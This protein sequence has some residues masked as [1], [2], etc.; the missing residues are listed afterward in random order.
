MLQLNNQD[1]QMM[2]FNLLPH[3]ESYN[4]KAGGEG[5]AYFVGDQFVVKKFE[6][7]NG[8]CSQAAFS[9]YAEEVQKFGKMGYHVPQIYA[10]LTIP[11]GRDSFDFYILEEQLKGREI[12][13][14]FL[15]GSYHLFE[16]MC[17]KMQF[18]ALMIDPKLNMTMFEE[19]FKRFIGDYVM[20]NE[21]LLD[22]NENELEK[23]FLDVNGMFKNGKRSTPDVYHGNVF[24]T[25][26]GL[27]LID[28]RILPDTPENLYGDLSSEDFTISRSLQLLDI[29]EVAWKDYLNY[30]IQDFSSNAKVDTINLA[31]K[32]EMYTKCLIE[33]FIKVLNRA[34]S[35]PTFSSKDEYVDVY[36]MMFRIFGSD[37]DAEKTL[38]PINKGFE[39]E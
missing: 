29:N 23:F 24:L 35:N 2:L 14:G 39:W 15:G 4:Q 26:S 13:S 10:W 27:A 36:D 21:M 11:K 32:H 25:D 17:S 8:F 37:E 38:K 3:L 7:N 31:S 20:V 5:T 22:M 1:F 12:Y 34:F 9:A 18:D 16:D 28:N 30:K 33:K 19:M 6:N